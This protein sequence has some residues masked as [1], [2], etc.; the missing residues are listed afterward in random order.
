MKAT[1]V[2]TQQA[3]MKPISWKIKGIRKTNWLW[4]HHWR[5]IFSHCLGSSF[6]QSHHFCWGERSIS[7]I[8]WRKLTSS[9]PASRA[10]RES[11]SSVRHGGTTSPGQQCLKGKQLK[12]SILFLFIFDLKI[13][14]RNNQSWFDENVQLNRRINL[15]SVTQRIC[16]ILLRKLESCLCKDR[17]NLSQLQAPQL[18]TAEEVHEDTQGQ[19]GYHDPGIQI[20]Q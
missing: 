12:G 20:Y 2:R 5:K 18:V 15:L 4:S 8:P 10:S 3:K 14:S 13:C 11:T 19:S 16:N 1:S 6:W 9:A 7:S 17:T